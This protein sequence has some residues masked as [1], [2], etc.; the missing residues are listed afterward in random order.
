MNKMIF[1]NKMTA[2]LMVAIA[3]LMLFI[4][5]I[6]TN[7]TERKCSTCNIKEPSNIESESYDEDGNLI[8]VL[9]N[10]AEITYFKDGRV[11]I[12]DYKSAYNNGTV[13]NGG[14]SRSLTLLGIVI[15]GI[16]STCQSIPYA[17]NLIFDHQLDLCKIAFDALKTN[18]KPNTGYFVYGQYIPG[19]IP[20]CEPRYSGPCN[21]GY[22]IYEVSPA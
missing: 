19:Y 14:N 10:G 3:M 5:G 1:T 2:F 18:A 12:K 15:I 22:W 8:T 21:Q 7:A 20:G 6:N 11:I 13:Y 16:W 4:P 17:T 9:D